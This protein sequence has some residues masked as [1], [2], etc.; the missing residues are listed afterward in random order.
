MVAKAGYLCRT[1]RP[2]LL[3]PAA[4]AVDDMVAHTLCS[5]FHL[6][7]V[8]F[9]AAAT[10]EQRFAAARAR[11][12]TSLKGV[13]LRSMVTTSNAAYVASMR[14]VAPS[15]AAASSPAARA[16]SAQY[17]ARMTALLVCSARGLVRNFS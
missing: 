6:D 7:P 17:E 15:I 9:S 12:P 3:L 5:A 11:L 16:L 1:V 4:R 10:A 2:D 14:A 8:I 13:G